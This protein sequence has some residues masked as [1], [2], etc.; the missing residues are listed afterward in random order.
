M[1]T[2]RLFGILILAFAGMMQISANN[3]AVT[4]VTTTGKNISDKYIMVQFD[5]SWDN[6]WRTSTGPSNWDAAWIFIKFRRAGFSSPW[7]HATL[8]TSGHTNPGGCEITTPTDG[9]G[10]FVYRD[11]D[12]IGTFSKTGIQIRWNYGVDGILD[13]DDFEVYVMAIEMVYVPQGSFA[14][15]SGG[16]ESNRFSLTTINTATANTVPSG[17]GSLGGQG[18]G[19]P[20]GQTAPVASWPNGFNGFYCMKYEITQE[21]YMVFLNMLTYTQQAARTS[22]GNNIASTGYIGYGALTSSATPTNRNGIEMLVNGVNNTVPAIFAMNLNNN[23]V[24]NEA[25]DGHTLA[26]NYLSWDDVA[27]YLDWASLRPLSELEYEKACR[28]TALPL[29]D[30]YA[31]GTPN[32]VGNFSTT[33]YTL[34]DPGTPDE[35]ITANY[36]LTAGNLAYYYTCYDVNIRGPLRA[37]IFAGS[38]GNSG[39]QTSG[40]GFYGIMELSGNVAERVVNLHGSY[41]GRTY[42]GV[43]GD[44]ELTSAGAANTT[45]W[46]TAG[47]GVG[48]RGGGWN[49]S[50]ATHLRVSDR[51]YAY[52]SSDPRDMIIGGRGVR[53]QP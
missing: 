34:T 24:Y 20:S 38:N 52:T 47:Y 18:G 30:E 19:Y 43:H 6:S 21:Q 1:K 12:G 9:K 25:A 51:T 14:A 45:A 11:T 40:A 49:S 31:W 53:T 13:N 39:R 50:T 35:V 7:M 41:T 26:C 2:A 22:L 8:N 16:T 42:T 3:I 15:G 36:S 28:G 10:V 33:Y 17:T 48:N 5:L 37:G 46:P 32:I 23:G 4:N 44:G 27:A 29:A